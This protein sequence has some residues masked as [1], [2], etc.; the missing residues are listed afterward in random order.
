MPFISIM[1]CSQPGHI[2]VV[3]IRKCEISVVFKKYFRFK[4]LV[5]KIFFFLTWFLDSWR[6]IKY[7]YIKASHSGVLFHDSSRDQISRASP[8]TRV[9]TRSNESS[10]VSV[11]NIFFLF[12]YL[13]EKYHWIAFCILKHKI[14][15]GLFLVIPD[16]RQW[17]WILI[18]ERKSCCSL[19]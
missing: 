16:A 11:L 9:R 5:K 7:K 14:H 18:E 15:L 19:G 4:S 8:L 1:S 17:I 3:N 10:K 6:D 12:I 13:F 2:V